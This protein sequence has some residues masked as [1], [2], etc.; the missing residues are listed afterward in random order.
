M[1]PALFVYIYIGSYSITKNI[2]EN[3]K[4]QTVAI[5]G[6]NLKYPAGWGYGGGGVADT[7]LH[8]Y[9]VCT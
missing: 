9:S 6:K 7:P 8:N 2:L 3:F 4:Y 5:Y 1:R